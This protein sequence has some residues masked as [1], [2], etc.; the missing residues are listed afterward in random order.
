MEASTEQNAASNGSSTQSP[1]AAHEAATSVGRPEIPVIGAF[2]GGFVFAK[3]LKHFG[4][5]DD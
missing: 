3:I 2:V 1:W 5:D 4:G